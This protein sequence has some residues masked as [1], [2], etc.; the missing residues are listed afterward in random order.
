[1]GIH[2]YHKAVETPVSFLKWVFL[3]LL[4]SS[5]VWA[6]PGGQKSF[7]FLNVSSNARLSGLGGVNVS[8]LDKDVNFF[9]SNPALV[10]D[11]MAGWGSLGYQFYVADIGVTS[12]TYAHDF[13]SI[14]TLGFGVQHFGYGTISGYD[15]T[16][17]PTADYSAGETVIVISKSHQV[18]NFRLGLNLKPA[19]SSIAGY[20]SSAL[21][22]DIGGTFVH[23]SKE[24]VVGM[25]IKN[26]GVV[27]QEYTETGS[28]TL[29]V[30]I[31]AGITFKPEYMP[32]RFSFT[33]H[34]LVNS[35]LND[36]TT[37]NQL[38]QLD[39]VLRHF[40]FGAE[41]LLHKKVNVLVGYN[42][43]IHQDLKLENGGG[44]AGV[45]FGFVARTK[46]FEFIFSRGGYV[47][48]SAGYSFSLLSNFNNFLKKS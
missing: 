33:A 18:G 47:A 4:V 19:F 35:S 12:F 37:D 14:G 17:A 44:G 32:L 46:F 15:Q 2:S 38:R 48:G 20:R 6:Q 30:D 13:N 39:K 28:S 21:L 8:Y 40:N 24:L 7:E 45:S 22:V 11:S 43:L 26:L 3:F 5:G 29:P 16:G 27:M 42:Y 10:S 41:I 25:V 34:Q 31:Q 1:M 36:E 9:Q 23:P